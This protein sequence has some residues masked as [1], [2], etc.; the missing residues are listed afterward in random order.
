[1]EIFIN[2]ALMIFSFLVFTFFIAFIRD[3]KG[4]QDSISRAYEKLSNKNK[5]IFTLSLVSFAL[6]VMYVGDSF[7]F[8]FGGGGI[9]VVSATPRLR[10]SRFERTIHLIGVLAGVLLLLIGL[11]VNHGLWI[12]VILAFI[13][14][15]II[16]IFA[17]KYVWG[18]EVYAF[19]LIWTLLYIVKVLEI[20][21]IF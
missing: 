5:V 8:F 6:P 11:G 21:I 4:T 1:M 18:L 12:Y 14:A 13:P 17:K 16:R 10:V 9:I 7:F 2:H 3:R 20:N 15:S 19:Y